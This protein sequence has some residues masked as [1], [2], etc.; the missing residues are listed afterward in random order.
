MF[1]AAAVAALSFNASAQKKDADP[2][3][4]LT[5]SLPSTTIVLDVE[6]VQEKFYAGPYAKY[7][8]KYLGIKARQQDEVSFQL[9]EIS[10]TPYVEADQSRRYSLNVKKGTIEATF[11]K[12]TAEGLISFSDGN[13]ATESIWRFPVDG[14][15]DFFTIIFHNSTITFNYFHKKPPTESQSKKNIHYLVY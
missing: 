8:E 12:L 6:A 15:S 10:M 13:F 4:F 3:G 14:K 5:Y 11:L 9:A 2:V 1:A 7:A